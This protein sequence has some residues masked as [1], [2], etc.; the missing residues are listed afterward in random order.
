MPD[1]DEAALLQAAAMRPVS[2]LLAAKSQA[3]QHYSSAA[4]TRPLCY[5]YSVTETTAIL[6][7]APSHDNVLTHCT[8]SWCGY[9]YSVTE[10]TAI[11]PS[12]SVRHC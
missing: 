6:P 7:S 11:L 12:R 9:Q 4:A 10:T 1:N 2:V 3:F 8:C 5:Q